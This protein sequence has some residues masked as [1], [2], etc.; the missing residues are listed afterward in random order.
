VEERIVDPPHG[1]KLSFKNDR[2]HLPQTVNEI[3]LTS[4]RGMR[5]M[6]GAR[7]VAMSCR[8]SKKA[9][10]RSIARKIIGPFAIRNVSGRATPLRR[11]PRRALDRSCRIVEFRRNGSGKCFRL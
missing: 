4:V 11:P 7:P 9:T 8:P 2:W 1:F 3:H 6:S 10:S 5:D